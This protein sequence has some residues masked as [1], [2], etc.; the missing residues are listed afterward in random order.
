PYL[1]DAQEWGVGRQRLDA[2]RALAVV[3]DALQR[4][5]GK[6]DGIAVALPAYLSEAQTSLLAKVADKARWH[7]LGSLPIPLA[8]AIAAHEQLL[9]SGLALVADLDGHALTWSAV[10]LGD[11]RASLLA[12]QP[13]T[14]L[15]R[16]VWLRRLLDG[17]ANRC[18][19]V[20]RRD[21]RESADAEQHLYDQL[22]GWLADGPTAG[23]IELAAQ[24]PQWYQLLTLQV[25]ELTAFCAPLV[26]QALEEMRRFLSETAAHGSVSI[27]LL[28]AAA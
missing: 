6:T 15:N 22:A 13:A 9:W 8:A 5:F 24:T 26:Q 28:T 19:R 25:E 10:A 3:F 12:S 14:R 21:P 23:A 20:S 16:D 27:V 2:T 7:L 11:E 1:G 17:V 18:V 4:R